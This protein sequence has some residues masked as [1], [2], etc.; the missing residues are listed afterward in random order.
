MS[1]VSHPQ[2]NQQPVGNRIFALRLGTHVCGGTGLLVSICRSRRLGR[3]PVP[4]T[5]TCQWECWSCRVSQ[6]LHHY[7][8][9][10]VRRVRPASRRPW[11]CVGGRPSGCELVS[12]F[13]APPWSDTGRLS[14]ACCLGLKCLEDLLGFCCAVGVLCIVWAASLSASLCFS[15]SSSGPIGYFGLCRLCF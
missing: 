2:F 10:T 11:F 1:L 14:R 7:S 9:T 3:R 4:F 15:F 6:W 8:P 12:G 5:V 13:N